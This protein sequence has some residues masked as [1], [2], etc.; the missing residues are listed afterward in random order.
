[1]SGMS[2]KQDNR[3]QEISEISRGLKVLAKDL[4]VPVIALSQL[5]RLIEHSN[6]HPQLSDLR[7]SG[8]LEQDADLVLFIWREEM[9]SKTLENEG[10]AELIIGKQRNGKSGITIEM[11]FDKRYCRFNEAYE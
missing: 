1:M 3:V 11:E 10:K 8:S 4:Q 7:E 2:K 6:R 9:R 5:N